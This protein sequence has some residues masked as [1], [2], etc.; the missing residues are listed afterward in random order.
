MSEL[1]VPIETPDTRYDFPIIKLLGFIANNECLALECWA[2]GK[3][4]VDD[5]VKLSDIAIRKSKRLDNLR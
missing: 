4:L 3:R 2:F 5:P 1:R